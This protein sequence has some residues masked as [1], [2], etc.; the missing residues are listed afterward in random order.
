MVSDKC[1]KDRKRVEYLQRGKTLVVSLQEIRQYDMTCAMNQDK[2][3]A[4]NTDVILIIIPCHNERGRIG[5]VIRQ[6]KQ[7]LPDAAI[8]VI[9]DA[10]T[11]GS[12]EEIA[13]ENVVLLSHCT[14]LGYGAALETGYLFANARGY[15]TV[16]QM[17]GDGQHQASQ[18]PALL[19]PLI[20]GTADIVIG[21]RYEANSEINAVTPMRKIGHKIFSRL[22]FI[23]TRLRISDPT[24]GFQALNS[25]AITLFSSGIFPCDY[26]DSD[27][28][29]MAHM[30]GLRIQ[31]VA[32]EMLPRAGGESMHSGLSPFYYAI[33]MA[34]AIIIVLLNRKLWMTWKRFLAG[35]QTAGLDRKDSK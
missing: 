26:P 35:Q 25:R 33:K 20:Q 27:V 31:E 15:R 28:I 14:N 12:Q 11:D 23:L 34:L 17:D 18:L 1:L 16:L 10:S 5:N 9:D 2:P 8:A 6:I 24:S 7:S 3:T 30:S 32:V 22:I 29:L 21:S 19:K 13:G 4:E